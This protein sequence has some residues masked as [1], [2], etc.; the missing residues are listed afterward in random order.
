MTIN[1]EHFVN[2]E[3][4]IVNN[5]G[6]TRVGFL[7][8][9]SDINSS[10][11]YR[12]HLEDGLYISYN[13]QGYCYTESPNDP[14]NIKKIQLRHQSTMTEP[15]KD[16]TMKVMVRCLTPEAIRYIEGHEKYAEMI[17]SLFDEFLNEKIGEVNEQ[18]KG[19]MSCF[20][21]DGISIKAV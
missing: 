6:N 10:F 15:L 5:C 20:F 14:Y 9:S 17:F 1:L 13:K 18:V 21:M 8:K 7:K 3:V 19:N 2:K 12:L 11:N 16:D 4:L